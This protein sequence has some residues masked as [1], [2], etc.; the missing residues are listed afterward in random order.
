MKGLSLVLLAIGCAS[1]VGLGASATAKADPLNDG[2]KTI[3]LYNCTGTTGTPS[4]FTVVKESAIPTSFHL[5]N[6]T[7]MFLPVALAEPG[8]PLVPLPG[9]TRNGAALITCNSTGRLMAGSS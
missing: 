8:D 6:S 5:L 2:T 4:S 9:F 3:T 7:S 1:I